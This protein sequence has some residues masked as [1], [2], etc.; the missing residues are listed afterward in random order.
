MSVMLY[1]FY[2]IFCHDF[3]YAFVE[4]WQKGSGRKFLGREKVGV[5]GG[6]VG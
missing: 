3:I 6:C 1:A 4:L 2:F 5:E